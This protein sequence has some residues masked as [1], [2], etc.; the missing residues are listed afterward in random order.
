MSKRTPTPEEV[1]KS[2]EGYRLL[3]KPEGMR[4]MTLEEYTTQ[5]NALL[6]SLKRFDFIRPS[7]QHCEHFTMDH[8]KVHDMDVPVEF[9]K[10]EG[11]CKE[12]VSDG[13]P[14]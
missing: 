13:L 3:W 4:G 7:C 10:K 2:M 11:E 14:F 12:W 1:A 5:R 6:Q 8:C 9:Q